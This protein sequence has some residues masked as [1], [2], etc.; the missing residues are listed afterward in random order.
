MSEEEKKVTTVQKLK[1]LIE[2]IDLMSEEDEWVPSAK[3]WRRIKEM[4]ET[5]EEPEPANT[6]GRPPVQTPQSSMTAPGTRPAAGAQP[7]P[8]APGPNPLESGIL[9]FPEVPSAIPADAPRAP[10]SSGLTPPAASPVEG[11]HA[12][13]GPSRDVNR[14]PDSPGI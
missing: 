5:L 10:S 1:S 7:A 13:S 2:A 3:Q 12:T 8:R 6:Y 4:I 11:Q 14:P 9:N